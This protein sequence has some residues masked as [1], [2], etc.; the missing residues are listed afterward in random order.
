M[1]TTTPTGTETRD[2]YSVEEFCLR[3]AI[4]RAFLYLLWKRGDGPAFMQLGSRRLI[5]CEAAAEWRA[6]MT[7]PAQRVAHRMPPAR[8]IARRAGEIV[9]T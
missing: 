8:R 1:N 7:A 5:S 6:R 2:A 4:S 9:A 3:H